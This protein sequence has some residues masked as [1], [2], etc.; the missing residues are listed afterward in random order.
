MCGLCCGHTF[1]SCHFSLDSFE[2]VKY[3]VHSLGHGVVL[4]YGCGCFL[5]LCGKR[6]VIG[7]KAHVTLYAVA[8]SETAVLVLGHLI[9]TEVVSIIFVSPPA[10]NSIAFASLN[11]IEV[12]AFAVS[13]CDSLGNL[14]LLFLV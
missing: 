6:I 2:L 13:G 1:Q 4:L 3:G 14:A 10:D 8:D 12:E 11:K 7:N 9:A 5:R